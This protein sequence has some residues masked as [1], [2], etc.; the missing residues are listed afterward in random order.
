ME[1][2]GEI[3]CPALVICGTEDALTPP[4]YATF[5]AQRLANAELE[6]IEGAGH[7]VMIEKPDLVA[8]AIGAA[9]AKW[10]V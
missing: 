8:A 4:K 3:R 5:L 10:K 2:L 9:L 7:M 1:Q 6:W